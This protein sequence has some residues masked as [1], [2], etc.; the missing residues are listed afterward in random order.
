[1]VFI[2]HAR[3]GDDGTAGF[4]VTRLTSP[5]IAVLPIDISSKI[6]FPPP[7][8]PLFFHNR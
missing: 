5:N 1:M 6:P 3:I 8:P 2:T 4:L 7:P